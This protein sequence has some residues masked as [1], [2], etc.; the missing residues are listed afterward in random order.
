MRNA[1]WL[2]A[3]TAL[4]I[5]GSAA[6][7]AMA[8][9]QK[10][11]AATD[12]SNLETIVVTAQK[13]TVNVQDSPLA[14]SAMTGAALAKA[15]GAGKSGLVLP[16]EPAVGAAASEADMSELSSPNMLSISEQ[17]ARPVS[18]TDRTRPKVSLDVA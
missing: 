17:A 5:L 8:A 2:K 18:A 12:G 3:T 4:V 16:T 1:N 14:I 15:A 6:I 11:P 7:P 10:A 9:A 13:R